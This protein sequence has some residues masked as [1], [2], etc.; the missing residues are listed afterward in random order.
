MPE[1]ETVFS[2]WHVFPKYREYRLI[3]GNGVAREKMMELEMIKKIRDTPAK[4]C[5]IDA[6]ARGE[7]YVVIMQFREFRDAKRIITSAGTGKVTWQPAP[8]VKPQ[9][10]LAKGEHP[11][12]D[13]P[14]GWNAWVIENPLYDHGGDV[15]CLLR[16]PLNDA[17]VYKTKKMPPVAKKGAKLN[18]QFVYYKIYPQVEVTKKLLNGLAKLE[19]KETK[20]DEISETK[21]HVFCGDQ[22]VHRLENLVE[23]LSDA[24]IESLAA[25]LTP[26]QRDFVFGYCRKILNGIAILQGPPGSGK[27]T[28]IKTIVK[29]AQKLGKKVLIVT[30]SNAAADNVVDRVIDSMWITTRVHPLG[31]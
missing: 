3:V 24:D 19:F 11:A 10:E 2:V 5:V 16:R 6:D 7:F 29:I 31:K 12:R 18:S 26:S 17:N 4:L 22:T 21:R 20:G 13:T 23:G 28:I 14:D 25:D 15:L 30:D 9:S 8:E 27:T 1:N